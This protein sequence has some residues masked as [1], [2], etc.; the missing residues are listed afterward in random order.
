MQPKS[1]NQTRLLAN[2]MTKGVSKSL[3]RSGADVTPHILRHTCATWLMQGG[4]NL[5]DAAGFLGMTV[6]QLEATYGH[7]HPDYQREA[8][9]ALGGQNAARN[10]VNESRQTAA[11]VTKI[12]DIS[13][14]E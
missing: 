2:L 12:A 8:I 10:T 13:K 7:H 3:T 6:Q 14:E 11:N 5:W 4:V 9:T 1:F